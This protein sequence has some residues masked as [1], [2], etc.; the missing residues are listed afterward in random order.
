LLAVCA[1][2][3]DHAVLC[4]N[5][6]DVH[7]IEVH[8]VWTSKFVYFRYIFRFLLHS[9]KGETRGQGGTNPGR[10]ITAGGQKVTMS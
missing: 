8:W 4:S 5:I 7:G 3:Q 2:L 10:R 9:S 1:R 6:T